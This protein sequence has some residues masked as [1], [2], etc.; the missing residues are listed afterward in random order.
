MPRKKTAV[1]DHHGPR[2][3]PVRR[4][5][6]DDY[7]ALRQL[8]VAWLRAVA[9]SRQRKTIPEWDVWMSQLQKARA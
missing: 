2:S 8:S 9:G 5:S 1:V 4:I 6:V 3:K 7:A